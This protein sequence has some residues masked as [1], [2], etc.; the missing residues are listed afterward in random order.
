MIARNPGSVI[1]SCSGTSIAVRSSMRLMGALLERST[2]ALV[3]A[4]TLVARSG[5]ALVQG[6][7]PSEDPLETRR[8]NQALEVSGYQA[9][10]GRLVA[11]VKRD[12]DAWVAG[13]RSRPPTFDFL[14]VS[15]GGDLG[16]FGAGFLRGWGRVTGPLERP[17]FTAVSGVSTGALLAPFAFLGDEDSLALVER[18]FRNPRPDWFNWRIPFLVR[19]SFAS[20]A[21][22]EREVR[23]HMTVSRLARIAESGKDG[24]ML[25]VNT[26]SLE[27]GSMRPWDLVAEA[28]RAV[29][30]GE[31]E[32][33][34][35][36]LLA[37]IAIPGI[38]PY[39]M[40]DGATYV[41]GGITGNILYGA[42]L[43]ERQSH[44]AAWTAA[45]PG[46]PIPATRFW[47]IFN[48]QLAGRAE[49]IARVW[50]AIVFRS[51]QIA[52][53]AATVTSIRHLLAQA[54]IARL[55]HRAT[56]EVRVVAIPDEWRR[57]RLG[58]FVTQDM[59]DLA[60]LG[61]RMG[62]DPRSWSHDVPDGFEAPEEELRRA[63]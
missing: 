52:I 14:I 10:L 54:E 1:G 56:M 44:L 5:K 30:A 61:A 57:S 11:H 55:R 48:G 20:M 8:K 27:D 33:W 26:T 41:D 24:R 23:E 49:P 29:R 63:A 42:R 28:E 22:L 4:V 6:E 31:V 21:G 59:N 37:S 25:I 18:V 39:R 35:R 32:R 62:T 51:I 19:P 12:H 36:I 43:R 15:G 3:R 47:V 40:I 17:R 7:S 2:S 16:A 34:H 60:D 13:K 45:Y 53:R 46:V 58:V 9:L 50:P 38:L